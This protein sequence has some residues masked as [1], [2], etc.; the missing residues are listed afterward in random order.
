M[1]TGSPYD[2]IKK[3]SGPDDTSAED[4]DFS[5]E[6]E[7]LN[8]IEAMTDGF[9]LYDKND[10]IVAFNQRQKELFPSASTALK[11]GNYFEDILRAQAERQQIDKAIGREEEWIRE[12]IDN[13]KN[14]SGPIIQKFA[15]G[16]TIR[17]TEKQTANGGTIAI[18]TNITELVN[19]Q[20]KIQES[21]E[22][23]R[24]LAEG[25]PIPLA[26]VHKFRFVYANAHMYRLLEAEPGSLIGELMTDVFKYQQ[27]QEQVH[28]IF[29]NDE[30]IDGV[31]VLFVSRKGKEIW[32]SVKSMP[33]LYDGNE[34][35]ITSIMDIS[36]LKQQ[37]TE[38]VRSS[39]QFQ[40]LLE[41]NP[42]AVLVQTEGTI[43]YANGSAVKMFGASTRDELIGKD[44]LSIVHPDQRGAVMS[45][46][47]DT[48]EKNVKTPLAESKHLKLDGTLIFTEVSVGPIIWDSKNGTMNIIRDIT[49]RKMMAQALDEEKIRFKDLTH[50]TSDWYWETDAKGRF[51]Y[52]SPNIVNSGDKLPEYF[53]GKTQ[54]DIVGDD[55]FELQ[56]PLQRL[57]RS[58]Q[59]QKSFRD[60]TYWR[61][62]FTSREKIWVRTSGI[63][64]YDNRGIFTGHRGSSSNVTEQRALQEQLE[65]AQKMEAIGQL[66]GGVAHDFNN[67][68]NVIQGNAEFVLESIEKNEPPNRKILENILRATTRGAELT[69]RMLAYSRKQDLNPQIIQL[70][71]E[72]GSIFD[73]LQR[74]IGAEYLL[75][76]EISDCLW[77]CSADLGQVENAILNLTINARDAMS[78]GGTITITARNAPN[79]SENTS[80]EPDCILLSVSDT[81]VG[82]AADQLEKVFEPF[83]TTKDIGKGTG[84]GLSM[85]YGF[86]QQSNGHATITSEL[87][88][89]TTV[90]LYLPRAR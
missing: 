15:S 64:I 9:I 36:A 85:V 67:L 65:Q 44:S 89:G 84:L 51:T 23:F 17:L 34:A 82:I 43:K 3:S 69:Q 4:A 57:E 90:S 13:H 72:L 75:Q 56:E 35:L 41:L 26:I 19:T 37:Q 12:R 28:D 52:M 80:G 11:I 30:D 46:R 18:R 22:R 77:P 6:S 78:D 50:A 70:K 20:K 62:T 5:L 7:L 59:E 25:S 68:L 2:K 40:D 63:P 76:M 49:D 29:L 27:H 81:G 45:R 24:V 16:Q 88:E 1:T 39:V 48:Q 86:A 14:P 31:E 74:T 42:D 53:I 38:L 87:G 58:F 61:Y 55:L 60:I 66:T 73:I 54:K 10:R 8:A 47:S 83:Y 79:S 71:T 21:E 32:G 33:I